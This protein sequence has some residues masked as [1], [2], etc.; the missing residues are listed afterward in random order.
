MLYRAL[1]KFWTVIYYALWHACVAWSWLERTTDLPVQVEA[2]TAIKY[3]LEVTDPE[4]DALLVPILP[5]VLDTY[6]MIMADISNDMVIQVCV[7]VD[8]RVNMSVYRE[9]SAIVVLL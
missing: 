9:S 1:R 4:M 8:L 5:N 7:Y 6:F 3:M 2:A